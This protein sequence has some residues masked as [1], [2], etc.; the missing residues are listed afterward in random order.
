MRL[1]RSRMN[2]VTQINISRFQLP[3]VE[4]VL[5]LTSSLHLH[6]EYV[7]LYKKRDLNITFEL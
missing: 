3:I 2:A 1:E 7:N 5:R 4:I 6:L